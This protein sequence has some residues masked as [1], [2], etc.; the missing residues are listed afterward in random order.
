MQKVDF[1]VLTLEDIVDEIEK[2]ISEMR[3]EHFIKSGNVLPF[4]AAIILH[5]DFETFAERFAD[6]VG[7]DELESFF[8]DD[9]RRYKPKSRCFSILAS[10]VPVHCKLNDDGRVELKRDALIAHLS[11]VIK[12]INDGEMDYTISHRVINIDIDDECVLGDG[13]LIHKL[14]ASEIGIKYLPRPEIISLPTALLPVWGNHCV[15]AVV[16][17]RGTYEDF[18]ND[19]R[20]ESLHASKNAIAHAY[21]LSDLESRHTVGFT[22]TLLQSPIEIYMHLHMANEFSSIPTKLTADGVAR[23]QR[24]YELLRDSKK[25][26]ILETAIDRFILGRRRHIH[27]P[28]RVNQPHWDKIVDY[29]IAMETLLLTADGNPVEQELSYRFRL[30]GASLLKYA[31]GEDAHKSF[32]ALKHLYGL[33]SKVVHGAPNDAILKEGNKFIERLG[34]DSDDH[35]HLIGRLMIISKKVEE[36]ITA[37]LLWIGDKEIGERP[38][39]KIGA[40]EQ[41]LWGEA[42]TQEP[43]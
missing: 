21:L 34:I 33:R 26:R 27:H 36:W 4:D 10:I 15:E 24:A 32:H 22:H 7:R 18:E 37:M 3:S 30:N 31:V 25:D 12:V 41:W 9:Q 20:I 11:K 28:N 2:S 19:H 16:V 35:K 29:V 43:V 40:W 1:A 14:P 6:L 5:G 38:Y 39:R 8:H 42:A 17:K 23:L 13:V